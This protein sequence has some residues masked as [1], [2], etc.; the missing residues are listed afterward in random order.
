MSWNLLIGYALRALENI[1]REQDSGGSS[2]WK[3]G[4]RGRGTGQ[5]DPRGPWRGGPYCHSH[6]TI[7]DLGRGAGTTGAPRGLPEVGVAKREP[8]CSSGLTNFG[9]VMK[10]QWCACLLGPPPASGKLPRRVGEARGV[11][12][13]HASEGMPSP[14]DG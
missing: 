1:Q 6:R 2:V 5:P 9:T 13:Q 10:S 7:R 3:I 12:S 14:D 4:L 8:S 11:R